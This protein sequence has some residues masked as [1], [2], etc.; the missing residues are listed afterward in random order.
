MRKLTISSKRGGLI[1]LLNNEYFLLSE[2]EGQTTSTNNI[3]MLTAPGF[4]GGIENSSQV[5]PREMSLVLL[6]K[7]GANVE[8]AKRHITQVIKAKELVTFTLEQ[9]YKTTVIQGTVERVDMPR[10]KQGVA[11]VADFLCAQPFWEDLREMQSVISD[12]IDLHC[13][14]EEWDDDVLCFPEEG[15]PFGVYNFERQKDVY[16]EGDVEIGITIEIIALADVTNPV[17]YADDGTFIGVNTTMKANDKVVIT[18]HKRRKTIYK[19]G[20]NILDTIMPKSTWLMLHTGLNTF[21]F[22]SDDEVTDNCYFNI[23]YKQRYI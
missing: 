10:Y 15:I 12:V 18:T 17:I 1:D 5:Q 14:T 6:V 22:N 21:N 8:L 20:E 9:E 19:N 4:D 16:N 2:L 11:F 3:S 7:S 23:I 13:F